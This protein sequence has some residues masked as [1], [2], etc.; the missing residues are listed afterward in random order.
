V[1][2]AMSDLIWPMAALLAVGQFSTLV[3]S[4]PFSGRK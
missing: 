1:L 2:L 3:T 4:A